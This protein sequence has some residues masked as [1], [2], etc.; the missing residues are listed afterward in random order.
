MI[1]MG[2]NEIRLR[3]TTLRLTN[4]TELMERAQRSANE[5]WDG[6]DLHGKNA[7][8]NEA[9][10]RYQTM[11]SKLTQLKNKAAMFARTTGNDLTPTLTNLMESASDLIDKF[12]GMDESTRQV[13]ERFALVA[14]AVGPV[15]LVLGKLIGAVGG[16]VGGAG[17]LTLALGKITAATSGVLVASGSVSGVLG[18]LASGGTLAAAGVGAVAVAATVGVS[19]LVDYATGAKKA[20]KAVEDLGETAKQWSENS[21]D[22]FY[23]NGGNKAFNM[24]T[25]DYT[26]SR[27]SL[28]KWKDQVIEIWSDGEK[29]T[30]ETVTQ[31]TNDFK[32]LTSGTRAELKEL[33]SQA[34]A[35]GDGTLTKSLSKDLR[36]LDSIDKDVAYLLNRSRSRKLT[37]KEKLRLEDLIQQGDA[38]RIKYRLEPQSEGN[39]GFA[40][41]QAQLEARLA[42]LRAAGADEKRITDAYGQAAQAAAQGYAAIKKELDQNY[43]AEYRNIQQNKEGAEK[44]KAL[45]DLDTQYQKNRAKATQEYAETLKNY[46]TPV[47]EE[48]KNSGVQDSVKEL[49]GQLTEYQRLKD[50]GDTQGAAAMLENIQKSAAELDQGQLTEFYTVLTQIQGLTDEGVDVAT[51][52]PE[53]DLEGPMN[54]LASISAYLTQ[55]QNE[56]PGLNSMINSTLAGDIREIMVD[57]NMTKAEERWANFATNPGAISTEAVIQSYQ[58]EEAAKAL[59]PTCEAAVTAYLESP[60]G[61]EK[62]SPEGLK[63]YVNSYLENTGVD[64]SDLQPQNIQAIVSSYAKKTGIDQDSEA[65]KALEPFVTAWIEEY[66]NKPGI[67][68]PTEVKMKV[69]LNRLDQA[70]LAKFTALNKV[71]LKANV[72]RAG[73]EFGSVEDL[74]NSAEESGKIKFYKDGVEIP[75]NVAKAEGSVSLNSLL[76]VDENGVFHVLIVPEYGD[77]EAIEAARNALSNDSSQSDKGPFSFLF[78]KDTQSEIHNAAES[79]RQV[80][81]TTQ[82]K[83]IERLEQAQAVLTRLS[84]FDRDSESGRNLSDYVGNLVAAIQQGQTISAQDYQNLLDIMTVLQGIEQSGMAFDVLQSIS[85]GL[86]DSE[87]MT[88]VGESLSSTIQTALEGANVSDAATVLGEDVASGAGQGMAGYSFASDAETTAANIDSS[89][90]SAESSHSPAQRTFPIGADIAAGIGEGMSSYS[91]ADA[92]NA[93]AANVDTAFFG[94]TSSGR[95]ATI[96]TQAMSGVGNGMRNYNWS[97]IMRSVASRI[98][99]SLKSSIS[100]SDYVSVGR[101]MMSGIAKGINDGKSSVVDA[102]VSAVRDAISAAKATAQIESPSKVFQNEVGVMMMRGLSVGVEKEAPLT[103]EVLANATRHLTD[104]ARGTVASNHISNDNRRS[105]DHSQSFNVTQNIYAENTSYA[106]QQRLAAR[107]LMDIA[108]RI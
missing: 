11:A 35:A 104:I 47:L 26:N 91:L 30:R 65:M 107:N 94:V 45:A 32:D 81:E 97:S 59:A 54:T 40:E 6:A 38:I 3:D 18:A 108:R 21:P 51:L 72:V 69:R 76:G 84:T 14:A 83:S 16:V 96:G 105:Y 8:V 58:D 9:N 27:T 103:A 49:Y 41:L 80:F 75:V 7:L 85:N 48:M 57:L 50:S 92:A 20:R 64:T 100:I 98:L 19:A 42:R 34:K 13:I 31:W 53:A 70:E 44:S 10:K 5:A 15:V 61:A 28:Q 63:A 78:R 86:N 77:A 66:S 4:A 87:S 36:T 25:S 73:T 99:S 39:E 43:E 67:D 68:T 95:F 23:A 24:S 52:F 62:P 29:E 60:G 12:L 89:L 17:K 37:E 1:M 46:V 55:F 90:R 102:M 71:T 56:L 88:D 93:V 82:P 33:Q 101:N 74:F 22:T 79:L 106:E 2:F